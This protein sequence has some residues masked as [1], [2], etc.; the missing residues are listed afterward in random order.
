MEKLTPVDLREIF[1]ELQ[2]AGLEAERCHVF[3]RSAKDSVVLALGA[4]AVLPTNLQ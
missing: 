1:V 2:V 4:G 3:K